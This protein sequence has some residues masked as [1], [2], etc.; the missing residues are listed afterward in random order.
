MHP[1][2]SEMSWDESLG[3]HLAPGMSPLLVHILLLS[4]VARGP[5]HSALP[6]GNEGTICLPQVR[7]GTVIL[8]SGSLG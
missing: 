3:R 6:K 5:I 8:P 7:S 4:L 1:C 2:C